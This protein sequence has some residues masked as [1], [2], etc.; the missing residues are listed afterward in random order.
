VADVSELSVNTT[1][2]G[3]PE[4]CDAEEE[5]AEIIVFANGKGPVAP[6][7]LVGYVV[8]YS[9]WRRIPDLRIIFV[10]AALLLTGAPALAG[11]R[12]YPWCVFGEELGYSGDC[13]YETRTQCLASASG[14]WNTSCSLNPRVL[15]EQ[16]SRPL[17]DPAPR[18]R[19]TH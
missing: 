5:S 11:S 9:G 19:R 12:D 8:T 4:S 6:S 3:S 7:A 10:I 2:P 18:T 13:S 17:E 1:F 14:R 16:R 15:F